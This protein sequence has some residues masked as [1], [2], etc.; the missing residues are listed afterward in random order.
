MKFEDWRQIQKDLELY[1]YITEDLTSQEFKGIVHIFLPF[2]KKELK[3]KE[4]PKIH[5]VNNPKFAKEIAAFGQIKDH[6]IVIDIQGRQ[7]MD[8]LRT[9][10]HEL[11]HYSQHLKGIKGDGGAGSYTENQANSLAGEIVRNFGEKHSSLFELP[12]Y[13]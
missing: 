2:V 7:V 11:V 10:A 13:K 6:R 8:I 1:Q 3:L 5:F 9:L 4:L 12:S